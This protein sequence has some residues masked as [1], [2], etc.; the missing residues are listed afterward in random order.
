MH[1]INTAVECSHASEVMLFVRIIDERKVYFG[2][3]ST[4]A[5]TNLLGAPVTKTMPVLE[6]PLS[7]LSQLLFS[8]KIR[9]L[10]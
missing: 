1:T 8:S 3:L 7:Q 2:A 4:T 6:A 9:M 5:V 10:G